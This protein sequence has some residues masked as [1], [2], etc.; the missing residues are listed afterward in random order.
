VVQINLLDAS[1]VAWFVTAE[2]LPRGARISPFI[3][4]PDGTEIPLN[5]MSLTQD[6]AAGESFDLPNIRK[7]GPFWP[8]GLLTYG[9]QVDSNGKTTQAAADFPV[10]AARN[11]DDVTN[12]VPR[13]SA[14]SEG[15]S[16]RDV[17][18]TIGGA[19]TSDRAY[20][21]LEDLVAPPAA[22]R[23]SPNEIAVNLSRVPGLDLGVMQ[24]LLLTV[25]QS[26]WCD[27]AIFRHTPPR[28]GTFNTAPQ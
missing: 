26:G 22:I 7:F 6:V 8:S 19:F 20:V 12:M 16:N 17:I 23:V 4:L 1:N 2:G 27:T 13:I 18:L 25:G 15:L 28:P 24:E 3:V 10:A 14:W 11:Y 21:L 5:T 9:V